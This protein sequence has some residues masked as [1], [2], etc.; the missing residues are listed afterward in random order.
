[1]KTAN[2]LFI[3]FPLFLS[4]VCCK[5]KDRGSDPGDQESVP[6]APTS[7]ISITYG[8]VYFEEYST[9][10]ANTANNYRRPVQARFYD[11]PMNSAGGR[12]YQ[13][14][15]TV[16]I[17]G[18]TLRKVPS[19]F[20]TWFY[21][22]TTQMLISL[23]AF[24]IAASGSQAAQKFSFEYH[25]GS[26][27]FADTSLLPHEIKRSEG[28]DLLLT[29]IS[30]ADSV[31]FSLARNHYQTIDRQIFTKG[32][33]QARIEI[34]SGEIGDLMQNSIE[35]TIN[36]TVFRKVFVAAGS[37]KYLVHSKKIYSKPVLVSFF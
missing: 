17:N 2:F 35:A 21:S 29:N 18:I 32:G 33:S 23:P 10:G 3:M 28:V 34:S 8:E 15:G 9:A 19:V 7:D 30:N 12:K 22:D 31:I 6:V 4:L 1:M 16:S 20:D 5:K 36:V 24:T 11:V 14:V 25:S 26:P 27:A 13:D 37:R